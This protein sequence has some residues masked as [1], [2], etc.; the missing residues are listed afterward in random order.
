MVFFLLILVLSYAILQAQSGDDNFGKLIMQIIDPVTG[1]PVNEVFKV[2]LYDSRNSG[3]PSN[4]IQTEETDNNGKIILKLMPYPY[5]FQIYPKS[6][7][8]NYS[9]SPYP[10]NLNIEE[11]PLIKT[12]PGKIT[13]LQKKATIA[14]SIHILLYDKNNN[15]INPAEII[16]QKHE[17]VTTIASDFYINDHSG[18]DDLNDGELI[19]EGLYPGK[20]WIRVKFEGLGFPRIKRE[21]IQVESGKQ[22]IVNIN[23]DVDDNTGV[24]GKVVDAS[25]ISMEGVIVTFSDVN[26]KKILSHSY[27]A[28]TDKSGYYKLIGMPT[29]LYKVSYNY[30]PKNSEV[31]SVD[32]DLKNLFELKKG[33]LLRIDIKCEKSLIEL[34]ATSK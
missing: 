21:N 12:E 14:G 6:D 32:F 13:Y 28:Y 25:G 3:Y 17:I 22:T 34:E 11:R 2:I 19:A 9:Y 8:S 30:F 10:F 16:K 18:W 5:Y 26:Q 29:G 27:N 1:K 15:R 31:I 23:L 7:Q 20:Y 24:E 33:M 4:T